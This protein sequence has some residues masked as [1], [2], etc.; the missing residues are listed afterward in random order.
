[1]AG[2]SRHGAH[3]NPA[4]AAALG[5][6]VHANR[7]LYL[8]PGHPSTEPGGVRI[9]GAGG[10]GAYTC[11]MAAPAARS[12][13]PTN[14]AFI[15]AVRGVAALL[16]LLFH[17]QIHTFEGFPERPIPT[18]SATWWVC[19]GWFDLGKFAVA[20]FFLVSGYLIP[21][22]LRAQGATLGQFARRRAFRLYPAY[23][24]S[25]ALHALALAAIGRVE[26]MRWGE[27]AANLTMLQKF[28]GIPD[29]IGVFW[30]LQ[31]E[32]VFYGVCAWLFR[33]GRLSSGMPLQATAFGLAFACAAA[34]GITGKALPVALFLAL[35]WMFLG[36][37]L[38]RASD[39]LASVRE[40]GLAVALA[41]VAVVPCAL[42]GYGDE[43]WR[44]VRTYEA[45]LLV[46]L[47]VRRC[48]P[49]FERSG[50]PRAVFGFLGRT[51]YGLYLTS[52][53]VLVVVGGP[54]LAATGSRWAS[55]AATLAVA[56]PLAWAIHRWVEEPAI[57]AG[58]RPA[59]RAG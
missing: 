21:G 7:A 55:A 51:S 40:A 15:D 48:A 45:S 36:D 16:V 23:W 28:V 11:P 3:G 54:V 18:G 12:A 33:I 2:R 46:F 37:T 41:A 27:I 29:F 10:Y 8:R 50:W 13:S 52:S 22:T 42:L 24:S 14:F 34:R 5:K 35:G 49:W 30:T 19:L 58:R 39:G 56:L 26:S 44:Y 43:G 47:L 32:L 31:I 4:Y 38:R 9:P 17:Q 1:M 57:A 53:T 25:I 6:W 20:A 59:L